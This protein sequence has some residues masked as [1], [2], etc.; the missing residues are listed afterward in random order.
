VSED[1]GQLQEPQV[2]HLTTIGRTSGPPR[3]IEIWFVESSG[4]FYV[5]SESPHKTSWFKRNPR[6][7]IRMGEKS[8]EATARVLD[9]KADGERYR[10]AQRCIPSRSPL[11]CTSA[12]PSS[13]PSCSSF[14]N[15][16]AGTKFPGHSS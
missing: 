3:E 9:P 15:F 10:K 1:F 11:P 8:F 6:V 7:R 4:R 12:S 14:T 13:G 5:F 2:V 16:S